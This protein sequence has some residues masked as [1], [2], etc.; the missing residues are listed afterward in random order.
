MREVDKNQNSWIFQLSLITSGL[1]IRL[2]G[3]VYVGE[4]ILSIFVL[5]NLFLG[6]KFNVPSQT[7]NL[8]TLLIIWFLA[9]F[10]SSFVREKSISLTLVAIFTV[11]ITGIC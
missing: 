8:V 6:R 10:I 3:D 4:I 1:S 2:L 9:N 5:S 11:I 7:R